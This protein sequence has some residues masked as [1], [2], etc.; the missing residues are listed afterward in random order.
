[1]SSRSFENST[2]DLAVFQWEGVVED[3]RLLEIRD[4]VTRFYTEE[5][6]VRA[7]DGNSLHLDAGETLGIVGESGSGR[8]NAARGRVF[9]SVSEPGIIPARK[10][11]ALI[12]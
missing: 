1:M 7:V 2:G 3:S 10:L 4:L 11:P 12:Q 8:K 9:V 6:I 5:G